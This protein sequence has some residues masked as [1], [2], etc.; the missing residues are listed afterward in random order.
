M[1]KSNKV[2]G[3]EG[4][5]RAFREQNWN[6]LRPI[7]LAHITVR[8]FYR[9]N[10]KQSKGELEERARL[11]LSEV[12]DHVLLEGKRNWNTVHYLTFKDFLISVIDSHLYNTIKKSKSEEQI[13]AKSQEDNS[14]L[15]AEDEMT[16]K[17]LRKRAYD[18]LEEQGATDEEI[19][20]FDCTVE[21]IVK[22]RD[23]MEDLEI[24]ELEFNNIWRTLKRKIKKIRE[25]F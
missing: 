4:I 6:E 3:Q 21:G 2:I 25:K 13:E 11:F 5:L 12:I 7:L 1:T 24:D 10:I 20:I 18:L 19:K 16:Y 8:L 22:P 15:S 9:Y 17:E 23:I 14:V